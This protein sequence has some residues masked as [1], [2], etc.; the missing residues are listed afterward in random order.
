MFSFLYEDI[1]FAHKLDRASSPD[2]EYG[3]HLH[4][5]VELL[6]F[7]SGS[8]VYHVENREKKLQKGDLILI[9]PGNY[10]FAEVDRGNLY[11]RY[12]FKFPAAFLPKHIDLDS[13]AEDP[14]FVADPL[15]LRL[16]QNFDSIYERFEGP[17]T[18]I[19]FRNQIQN[20]LIFLSHLR[21]E[22]GSQTSDS[23]V[24]EAIR[25]IDSHIRDPLT[26]EGIAKDLHFSTS[27]LAS[28]FK[29]EMK[30]SIMRYVR[31]KKIVLAHA[32]VS[33][34]SKPHEVAEALS[35]DDYSTFYRSYTKMIGRPPSGDRKKPREGFLQ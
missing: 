3:K 18:Y 19:L 8:V 17:D 1:D 32:L 34:G 14:F 24:S 25:Y 10:H 35:F 23:V 5:F 31:S 33:S 27:Y 2:D 28:R 7:V 26:L 21:T 20:L 4:V 12:V 13:L 30:T 9:A 16:I 29:R 22:G 11:E 6:Y 15:I